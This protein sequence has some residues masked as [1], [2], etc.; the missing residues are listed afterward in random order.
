MAVIFVF[1]FEEFAA[2]LPLPLDEKTIE[3]AR[4]V[5]ITIYG[6]YLQLLKLSHIPQDD[7]I[8]QR[9][10]SNSW[11]KNLVSASKN[12]TA[13]PSVLFLITVGRIQISFIVVF[14][15]R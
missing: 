5:F 4:S 10:L 2:T 8:A 11:M 9:D 1:A 14:R 13:S 3:T 7:V 15:S 12:Q 6:A